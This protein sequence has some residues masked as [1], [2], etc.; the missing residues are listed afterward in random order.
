MGWVPSRAALPR[1]DSSPIMPPETP[2]RGGGMADK[3]QSFANHARMV[4][5]YHY[6]TGLILLVLLFW[7]GRALVRD[8]SVLSVMDFLLVLAVTLT[9]FYARTFALGVQDRVIRL[10]EQLRMAEVLPDDLRSRVQEFTTEQLI[11]L[12]FASDDELPGLARKVLDEA[13]MDR[14]SIKAIVK[15]W[16]P[17]HQRV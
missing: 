7:T 15:D 3:A 8:F 6:I 11:G 2:M 5:G 4:P 1:A 13:I 17:D 16:R 14:R 12:R 9:A 10:E